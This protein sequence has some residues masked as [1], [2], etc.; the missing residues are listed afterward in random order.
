M[1]SPA[2]VMTALSVIRATAEL[3]LVIALNPATIVEALSSPAMPTRSRNA[4]WIA[5]IDSATPFFTGLGLGLFF[6]FRIVDFGYD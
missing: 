3:A 2:S 4:L 1:L 6:V 5:M